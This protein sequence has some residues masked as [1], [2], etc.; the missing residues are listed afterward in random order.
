MNDKLTI[1]LGSK[2][3]VKSIT[4]DILSKI[5]IENKTSDI[6]EYDAREILNVSNVFYNERNSYET[7]RIYGKIEYLSILNNITIRYKTLS[8]F[9]TGNTTSDFNK[10]I[11]NSFKFYLVKPSTGNTKITNDS[12]TYIKNYDIIATPDNFEL[13]NA[14]YNKNVYDEQEYQFTFDIDFDVSEYF[15]GFGN[16]ITDLYLFPV[17]VRS[18]GG[19]GIMETMSA[20]TW[21]AI[22]GDKEF[23]SF[24]PTTYNIGDVIYGDKIE[25][26]KSTITEA[27]IESQEYFIRTTYLD[28]STQKEL[29]WKYSPFLPLKLR[30][31]SDELKKENI[32][33]SS[34]IQKS[35]I[36]NYATDLG[37]GNMIWREI[38][39]QGYFDPLTGVGVNYPFINKKRY[40]FNTSVLGMSP[41]LDDS[42][43]M[44]VF[45]EVNF[46]NPQLIN[47]VPLNNIDNI[48]K[49]CQ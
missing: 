32:S 40:L 44:H 41:N 15:D 6:L 20:T 16:P 12:I 33:G 36:P 42:N 45:S 49:P 22:T 2:K 3:N 35:S 46:N 26:S 7:Y 17:F 21:N 47:H 4:V 39:P 31:V 19:L 34:Y 13:F 25:Y 10:D 27:L 38:L 18:T 48:G 30:Y 37:G 11:F 23:I 5:E 9:F 14:G 24:S 28:N 43:T 8:D 1:Q 29:S